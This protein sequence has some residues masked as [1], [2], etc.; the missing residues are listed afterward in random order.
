MEKG[1][2][3]MKKK[4]LTNSIA[5][6]IYLC[7]AALILVAILILSKTLY[8]Q[9]SKSLLEH[10]SEKSEQVL[11][12][13]AMNIENY[14]DDLYR[15]SL[16]PYYNQDVMDALDKKIADSNLVS[17]HR[18]RT[19]EDYLEQI[20]IT[21]RKDILR[22]FIFTDEIYRGERVPSTI[23]PQQDFHKFPWYQE[24]LITDKPILVTAHLEQTIIHPK[25]IVFSI[26]RS[27]RSTRKIERVLGVIKVDANFSSI[28]DICD[29]VDF[30]SDGGVYIIDSSK[31]LIYSN[32][33]NFDPLALSHPIPLPSDSKKASRIT[34]NGRDYLINST[35]IADSDWSLVGVTAYSTINQRISTVRRSAIL[36]ASLC[37]LISLIIVY[38]YLHK[39][40]NPLYQIIHSIRNVQNGNLS[41]RFK[42]TSENEL[43]ELAAALN[44]MVVNLEKVFQENNALTQQIYE[45]KYL[46]KEAQILSLFSQIQPHF[47]YNTLNMI[48]MQVQS[49]LYEDAVQ[50][51]N[52]LSIMLRGLSHLDK[53]IQIQAEIVFLNAYLTIQK[54]RYMD[55][56]DYAIDINPTISNYIIPA[57]ILQ[58][59]VEN[60]VKHCCEVKK[61]LTHIW[62]YDEALDDRIILAVKDDGVG[63]SQEQ[64]EKLQ[65]KLSFQNTT[66]ENIN[67][68]DKSSGIALVNVNRRLQIK[69]GQDYGIQVE[70]IENRG[71]LVKII[72]PKK[73]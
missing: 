52:Q 29:K 23:D 66:A 45:A 27:L 31:Q 65:Y 30:G 20:L 1:M 72:L 48:S 67:P 38:I 2:V 51:I 12:L 58:P 44:A 73:N 36:L 62:V 40:L 37:F 68:Y 33:P 14:L 19:I 71:T 6:K 8:D 42:Q 46:Q 21:P 59:I 63:M 50:N 60:S 25:N 15:L 26:V 64:L 47:I 4:S 54:N 35:R 57:L 7:T 28:I 3:I 41:Y 70:S 5:V 49:E 22:V 39:F 56:L 43:G 24:A 13:S 16:S 69:Y 11:K 10:S 9:Y 55:R 32:V 17:L 34:V 61:S 18:T 53:D